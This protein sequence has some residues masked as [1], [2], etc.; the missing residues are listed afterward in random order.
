VWSVDPYQLEGLQPGHVSAVKGKQFRRVTGCLLGWVV[1][2]LGRT[3]VLTS[4]S[5]GPVLGL[6]RT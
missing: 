1:I 2:A 5:I 3:E 6:G 4:T